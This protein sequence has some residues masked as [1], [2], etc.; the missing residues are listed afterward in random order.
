[1]LSKNKRGLVTWSDNRIVIVYIHVENIE[2]SSPKAS[3][4][5]G[6]TELTMNII[7]VRDSGLIFI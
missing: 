2:I 1:M 4:S 7:R 5:R 6:Y 3:S